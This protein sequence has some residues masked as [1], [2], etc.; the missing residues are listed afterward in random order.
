M[1]KYV[2]LN[3]LE[4]IQVYKWLGGTPLREEDM[5]EFIKIEEVEDGSDD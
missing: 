3:E 1:S 5:P 2:E 4:S